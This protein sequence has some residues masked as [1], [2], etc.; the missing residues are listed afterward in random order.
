MFNRKAKELQNNS[1]LKVQLE[2]IKEQK[3]VMS[4]MRNSYNAFNYN[5]TI[6]FK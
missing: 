3:R 1:D 5:N 6:Y 4:S 2:M